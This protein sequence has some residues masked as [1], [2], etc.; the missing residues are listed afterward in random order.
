MS[1]NLT[2]EFWRAAAVA[3]SRIVNPSGRC[4]AACIAGAMA[5]AAATR[6][7]CERS[8]NDAPGWTLPGFAAVASTIPATA[9]HQPRLHAGQGI[10]RAASRRTVAPV[11]RVEAEM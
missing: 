1:D 3:A 9:A 7:A 8:A 2:E 11:V 4:G 5:T 10:A 6:S